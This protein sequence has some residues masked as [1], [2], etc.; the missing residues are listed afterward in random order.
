MRKVIEIFESW[1]RLGIP[2]EASLLL[3]KIEATYWE[4]GAKVS[5]I[6]HSKPILSHRVLVATTRQGNGK[7]L[8][9]TLLR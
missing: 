4:T 5:L 8:W 6:S 3:G 9:K 1:E 2:Q 7:G